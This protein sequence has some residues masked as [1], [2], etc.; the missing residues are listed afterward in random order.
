MLAES[1]GEPEDGLRE[2]NGLFTSLYRVEDNR[3]SA[4]LDRISLFARTLTLTERS[5]FLHVLVES[6]A[7]HA[8]AVAHDTVGRAVG[9]HEN[10]T[11]VLEDGP[12]DGVGSH[13]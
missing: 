5:T 11:V 8:T 2:V 1:R 6:Q 9:A 10:S 3:C 12:G 4:L 7:L 13:S